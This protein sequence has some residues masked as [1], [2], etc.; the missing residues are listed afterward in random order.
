LHE[1]RIRWRSRVFDGR[2]PKGQ[3]VEAELRTLWRDLDCLHINWDESRVR[4]TVRRREGPRY[5]FDVIGIRLAR[6]DI[7]RCLPLREG[8]L[9]QTLHEAAVSASGTV[10][11][12]PGRKPAIKP[13]SL[14]RQVL[15]SLLQHEY[16]PEGH[17]PAN[18]TTTFVKEQAR[19]G[20]ANA[21]Q[22]RGLA[23]SQRPLPPSW[24]TT[25]RVL[26][27]EDDTKIHQLPNQPPA[28]IC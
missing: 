14:Q 25:N 3:T 10:A 13:E 16:P 7:I 4:K 18:V 17:V 19:S 26:G 5:S 11:A 22:A 12:G 20:W 8:A 2:I 28:D 9:T 23:P 24:S 6:D 1:G 27:R 21:C 15:R